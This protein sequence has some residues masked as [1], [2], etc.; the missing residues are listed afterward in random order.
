MLYWFCCR[1]C[2]QC[3]FLIVAFCGCWIF[4]QRVV[5]LWFKFSPVIAVIVNCRSQIIVLVIITFLS[6]P[7]V[8][9]RRNWFLTFTFPV[10]KK[11]PEVISVISRSRGSWSVCRAKVSLDSGF[12]LPFNHICNVILLLVRYCQF[13]VIDTSQ[14]ESKPFMDKAQISSTQAGNR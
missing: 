10:K 4:D 6:Q 1:R 5:T 11:L 14:S 13:L 9:V 2:C 3:T 8:V 12:A 7:V